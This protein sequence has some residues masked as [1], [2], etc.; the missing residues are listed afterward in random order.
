MLTTA[1]DTPTERH[2]A[3][4][5]LLEVTIAGVNTH[6]LVDSGAEANIIG[7]EVLNKLS[8]KTRKVNLRVVGA[9]AE[10]PLDILGIA[11]VNLG[12]RG[13][14]DSVVTAKISAICTPSYEGAVVLSLATICS[15]GVRLESPLGGTRLNV[16]FKRWQG[17]R[18]RQLGRAEPTALPIRKLR[19]LKIQ[20]LLSMDTGSRLDQAVVEQL[21][22]SPSFATYTGPITECYSKPMEHVRSAE[23]KTGASLLVLKANWCSSLIE[24]LDICI[25]IPVLLHNSRGEL[26]IAALVKDL[27]SG[28]YW[29]SFIKEGTDFLKKRLLSLCN[30]DGKDAK[31]VETMAGRIADH[32]QAI[33]QEHKVPLAWKGAETRDEADEMEEGM[34]FA[35][36]DEDRKS[37]PLPD[38]D[39]IRTSLKCGV[40]GL[41]ESVTKLLFDNRVIL[42]DASSSGIRN[43]EHRITLR[44]PEKKIKNWRR[45]NEPTTLKFLTDEVEKLVSGGYITECTTDAEFVS[46]PVI[47][48]KQ[49]KWRLCIDYRDVNK[50]TIRDRYNLPNLESCLSMRDARYFSSL[51]A[52][53]R[54]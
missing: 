53:S 21:K 22:K 29:R 11:E 19:S 42:G 20:E 52:D 49:K 15:W 8:F 31:V 7:R 9:N 54:A 43:H 48:K 24:T 2:P 38:R 6:A 27:P 12:L 23:T 41:K 35:P 16:S 3:D 17:F 34:I 32:L 37:V 46:A 36:S 30:K 51:L 14:D 33:A 50:N 18:P 39:A 1:S 25:A 13:A 45:I 4:L 26:C 44:D 5:C 47:V 10:H 28:R 40:D